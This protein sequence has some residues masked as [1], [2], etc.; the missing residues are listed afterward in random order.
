MG[1]LIDGRWDPDASTVEREGGRF[2]RRGAQFRD[3]VSA[4]AGAAFP[5]Q[6]GRYHLYVS[7]Q[8]PWAWRT[9]VYRS[10]KRLTG[11]IG[12]SVAIPDGRREGWRFGDAFPG[13]TFDAAEGF[14]HLHQAY[15]AAKPDYTGVVSVPV[16]WDTVTR[17]IVNN[18]SADIIE[19]LNGAFDAFTDARQDYRPAN[20]L[21]EIKAKNARLYDGLNNAVYRAGAAQ[22][23]EAYDAAYHAVFETL[24]WAE[25]ILA[26]HRFMNGERLTETDWRLAAS[27]FRFDAVYHGLFRCNARRLTDYPNLASYLRELYQQPGVAETVNLRHIVTGY[28]SQA[29]NPSGLIPLGPEGYEVWLASPYNRARPGRG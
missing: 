20:L 23:Q 16:L 27:L 28:Y 25:A 1:L 10:L 26:D 19:I 4:E 21:P 3:R 29:W 14:T 7:L 11:V 6:P 13:A 18:E 5:A 12:M 17:R 9:I 8:C 2:V 15:V 22:T 24:D